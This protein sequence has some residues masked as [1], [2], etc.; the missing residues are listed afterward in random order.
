MRQESEKPRE[1]STRLVL[2]NGVSTGAFPARGILRVSLFPVPGCCHEPLVLDREAGKSKARKRQELRKK[3]RFFYALCT[4]DY[5]IDGVVDN[6]LSYG[7]GTDTPLV[8]KWD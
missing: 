5:G 8:G 2:F 4:L 7:A 3:I 1:N 6:R